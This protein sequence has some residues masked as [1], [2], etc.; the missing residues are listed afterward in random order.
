M[1]QKDHNWPTQVLT[2]S[3]LNN[4]GLTEVIEE[5]ENYTAHAV[6]N[7]SFT[8]KR[9]SQELYWFHQTVEDAITTNFYKRPEV[10]TK[11]AVLEKE[12]LG[13]IKSPFDAA[14]ELLGL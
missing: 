13:K 11:L 12:V 8:K 4:I 3:G 9:H 1:P 14:S 10:I 7:K 6:A 5:I 2:C